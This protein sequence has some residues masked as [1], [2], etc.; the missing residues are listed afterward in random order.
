MVRK[1]L[2]VLF[3]N[4]WYPSRVLPTN[5]DFIKR[6][7]E[8]VALYHKVSAIHVI[9]DPNISD[10]K[11]VHVQFELN[12]VETLLAYLPKTKNPIKKW[13]QY[14]R[15]FFSLIKEVKAYDII[16]LNHIYPAG[17]ATLILALFKSKKYIIS[18]HWTFY[19]EDYRKMI[20]PLER[21]ISKLVCKQADFI[22]PVSDELGEAMKS[23]GLKGK[24]MSVPNVVDVES[25]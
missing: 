4:S 3:L 24:Y 8:C 2:H 25:F 9:T 17:L 11:Q 12:G 20:K 1:K 23:F 6:H 19:H 21:S 15:A 13:V 22:C 16:H 7:A 14:I 5:G 10:G 18:E